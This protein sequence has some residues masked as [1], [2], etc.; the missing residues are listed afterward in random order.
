MVQMADQLVYKF[1]DMGLKMVE[2]W[3][4]SLF[5]R[6]AATTATTA[7]ETTA[8]AAGQ[9]AQTAAVIGGQTAQTGAKVAGAATAA[10]SEERRGGK[11]CGGTCR[12]RGWAV[13]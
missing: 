12:S 7:A 2:N 9:A 3:I 8:V 6:K 4:V 10:R 13:Y 1:M 11:E 5:T